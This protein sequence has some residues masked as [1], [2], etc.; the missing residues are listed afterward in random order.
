[1]I[2][3]ALTGAAIALLAHWLAAKR[4]KD[5]HD[6]THRITAVRDFTKAIYIVREHADFGSRDIKDAIPLLAEMDAA[7]A[8]LSVHFTHEALE[9]A[10]EAAD[11]AYKYMVTKVVSDGEAEPDEERKRFAYNMAF[12]LEEM[13]D[14][15]FK[16]RGIMHTG[17]KD[18]K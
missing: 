5:E 2:I 14:Y 8:V 3:T 18:A 11:A 7:C 15:G 10:Q 13:E 16:Y 17:T 6:R 4:A 1:M 12:F 9:A